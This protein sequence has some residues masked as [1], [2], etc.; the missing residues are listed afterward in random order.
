MD[1]VAKAFAIAGVM[2]A[3]W[4]YLEARQETRVARTLTYIER[5]EQG[6]AAAARQR[7]NGVLREYLPQFEAIESISAEDRDA[8]ILSIVEGGGPQLE[9]DI[10]LIADFFLGM[11]ICVQ[12]RLCERGVAERYFGASDTT[13]I[14]LNFAPYFHYRRAN[15]PDYARALEYFA[16]GALEARS[17]D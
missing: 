1:V 7:I 9:Q 5:F 15:N 2:F 16:T 6:D 3:G 13:N 8:M 14:W 17:R 12:E 11:S 4:Q 10:D